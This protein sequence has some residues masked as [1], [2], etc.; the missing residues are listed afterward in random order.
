MASHGEEDTSTSKSFV[1]QDQGEKKAAVSFGF[2]KTV[3][4]F[5]PS[6]VDAEIKKDYKDYLTGIDRNELQSTKPCEK[7]KEYIIPLIQKNRWHKPDRA[8]Q[9][10]GK[11]V[12]T[13]DSAPESESVDSQAVKELIEDSRRQLDEWQN[14]TQPEKN[15]NLSIPLLMQNKVPDGFEDGDHIKVD[16]RPESATEADYESIPVEAYGI[17]MLKGMGWNKEEGIGRTFK[18]DVKPIEHQLR[19][20]GLGLGADRSA[21][22]DLEPGKKR[23]PPKPGDEQEKEEELVMGPGGCVLVESGAHKELYGKIEGVDPDNAR[24]M[25]KLA[26]GGKTVTISQY[27]IKLVGRKEYEKYSKDLSRF[28]KASKEKEKEK[29]KDR[30]KERQ[31]RDEKERSHSDKHKSSE[32]EREGGRDERKRKHK[33]SS[34]DRE[35]PPEKE[36]RRPPA[37][38]SW[39][40]RDLKVRFIDKAFKGG[41]YYNS[42]MR[43]EDVLTPAICVCRTEEGRLL[44]DVKQDMLETIIPKSDNDLV[45]VVLGEHRGQIGRILQRD[46]NKCKAMVQLE[47]YEEKIFTLDYDLICHYVGASDH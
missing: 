16:L 2:T 28:S 6:A 18:Q 25:V 12:K 41:R 47:R 15:L 34:H 24:V 11:G 19:P 45:M 5:K 33:E 40:Q 38:P 23:R 32:R 36:A 39:L 10:E 29:E 17:A 22:K 3:S 8:D 20:K 7:P 46:K 35:R 13:H 4:K 14:G 44:D 1:S 9:S 43:V 27:G 37:P 26:V 21:I 30:D 31:R 42:K